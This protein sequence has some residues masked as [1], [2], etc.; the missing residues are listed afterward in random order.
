MSNTNKESALPDDS[1]PEL[2]EWLNPRVTAL[3]GRI[4][5]LEKEKLELVSENKDL[6]EALYY[7]TLH[8]RALRKAANQMEQMKTEIRFLE[9][10]LNDLRVVRQ[11]AIFW[12]EVEK[13]DPK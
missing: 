2:E 12:D 8:V 1:L 5:T 3:L 13:A 7:T 10:K 4:E 11:A 6:E 9:K